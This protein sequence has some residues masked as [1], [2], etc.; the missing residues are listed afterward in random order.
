MANNLKKTLNKDN[1]NGKTKEG[2]TP[3]LLSLSLEN[4]DI[5][6]YLIDSGACINCSDLEGNLPIHLASFF[7]L[8]KIVLKLIKKG[9]I[10]LGPFFL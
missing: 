2:I 10:F 1:I 4:E 3:L 9:P 7:G 5:S 6:N 8:K